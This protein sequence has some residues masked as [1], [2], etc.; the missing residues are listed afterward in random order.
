[1]REY[2]LEFHIQQNDYFGT[3]ATVLDLMPGSR[4]QGLSAA[5]RNTR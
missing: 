3:L 1:M 5:L 4:P 2:S